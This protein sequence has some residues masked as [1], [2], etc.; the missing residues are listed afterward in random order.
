MSTESTRADIGRRSVEWF[1]EQTTA[2]WR[3]AQVQRYDLLVDLQT[4]DY[5]M[6]RALAVVKAA[7]NLAKT[8]SRTPDGNLVA[9]FVVKAL[10]EFEALP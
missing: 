1:Q 9:H 8:M 3:T 5:R 10:N 4:A 2:D 7:H 6:V